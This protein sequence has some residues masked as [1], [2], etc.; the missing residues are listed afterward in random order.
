MTRASSTAMMLAL[1]LPLWSGE[2][3]DRTDAPSLQERLEDRGLAF[4]GDIAGD[5][6]RTSDGNTTLWNLDA[7]AWVEA[8]LGELVGL[9]HWFV[10]V[11]PTLVWGAEEDWHWKPW[12]YQAWVT[13]DGSDKFNALMGILDLSWHFHS[14]P[15]A[16]PFAR[17]PARTSGE[18]SPGSIGLLDLYPLSAPS[19]RMEWKPW[20]HG[21]AQ[22]ATSWLEPD[23]ELR[24]H[25][26]PKDAS[27]SERW[28]V[29]AEAGWRD[30]GEED[31]GWQHR[32]FGF[33]GWWL[34]ADDGWWGVY[35]FADAKLWS[36]P[37]LDWQGMSG[38]ISM[39][40]A[41]AA[42]FELE[43][44][45]VSGLSYAGLFPH[46]DEDITAF[47]IITENLDNGVQGRSH[48]HQRQA[49]ELLHR[50][51]VTDSLWIQASVQRQGGTG[52]EVGPEWLAG[53]RIGLA[54]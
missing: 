51:H 35:A 41:Q 15:S 54:F 24:G 13:W 11:N 53:L 6:I 29:I 39:S 37:Q 45:L 14:L 16:T 26:L 32:I 12:L 1:A 7:G 8:D 33:G 18:F 49:W 17:L 44:R 48:K 34:P 50:I 47:A 22:A 27:A 28:L 3:V 5:L 2:P 30:E 31:S 46:R 38:F 21:Y 9:D 42:G 36:E 52:D 43:E 23:H 25:P 40:A 10:F 20:K 4:G 19:V